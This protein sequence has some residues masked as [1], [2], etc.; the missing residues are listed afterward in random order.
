MLSNAFYPFLQKWD[1]PN[2]IETVQNNFKK[3]Q[4]SEFLYR[5]KI[6]LITKPDKYCTRKKA[7]QPHLSI[8]IQ[9]S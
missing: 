1:I 5:V 6:M 4:L 8:I 9:K 3:L 2:T 7:N